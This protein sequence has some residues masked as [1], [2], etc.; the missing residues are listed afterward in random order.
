M[1]ND[2]WSS[3]DVEERIALLALAYAYVRI[4]RKHSIYEESFRMSGDSRIVSATDAARVLT[5]VPKPTELKL[6]LADDVLVVTLQPVADETFRSFLSRR[7]ES[8][9]QVVSHAAGDVDHLRVEVHIAA[10]TFTVSLGEYQRLL[11]HYSI[12]GTAQSV[13]GIHRDELPSGMQAI[14]EVEV[15]DAEMGT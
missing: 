8:V 15:T 13:R 4:A 3:L 14:A 11:T 10:S 12:P 5:E 7:G 6:D 2:A 9:Y 1:T